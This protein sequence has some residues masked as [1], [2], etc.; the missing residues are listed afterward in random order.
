[1]I[2]VPESAPQ[3]KVAQLLIFGARVF[4]VRGTYDQASDLCVA[5]SKEFGW[6]CRNTSYN[7]Y[8]TEGKKTCALE[9]CEQLAYAP[10]RTAGA[11]KP[12]D[13]QWRAP[14]RIVVSVGDG[15]IL[16]GTW[17]GLEDLAT[18][19]W[20]DSMPKLVGVQAEGSAA[21][22]NAWLAGTEEIKPV[23]P[24]TLADSINVGLPRD[25]RRAV[26]AVRATGG[27]FLT[28]SDAEILGAIKELGRTAAVFAEPA[29]AAAYAGL[30]KSARAGEIDRDETVVVIITGSGLKDIKNAMR[31][32]GEGRVIEPTLD[33]V[34]RALSDS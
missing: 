13:R 12:G 15:N 20:I 6:Y 32:A 23:N 1:V 30:A 31:A 7:P 29:A 22:F 18:M 17:K 3:A 28:V 10:H 26:R 5:A 9:I 11:Y 25:G 27:K 8:T 4:L 33:A 2:F 34:K 14:D 16:G 19:G 21:C 24:D